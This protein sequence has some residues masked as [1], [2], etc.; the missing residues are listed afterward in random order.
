MWR[1]AVQKFSSSGS[2]FDPS[3]SKTEKV[4]VVEVRAGEQRAEREADWVEMQ[5]ECQ[6]VLLQSLKMVI[7]TNRCARQRKVAPECVMAQL[8][9]L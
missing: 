7:Y 2:G 4:R 8:L 3:F 6:A 9:R 1:N 5:W